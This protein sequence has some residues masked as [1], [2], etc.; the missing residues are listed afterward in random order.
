MT[1]AGAVLGVV[2]FGRIGQKA[3][4][5]G[6]ALGMEVLAYDPVSEPPAEVRCTDLRDL[7]TRSDVITLH[8]PLLET[9]Q[10][11]VDAELLRHVKPGAVLV[12]CGRG[13]LVDMDAVHAA[14]LDGRLGGV[15]LDVFDPEP[16]QHHP[17]FDHP[18]VVLTPHLMGLSRQATSATFLDAARGV[19]AVLE[20]P[21]SGGRGQPRLGAGRVH[22]HHDGGPDMKDLLTGKVLLVSGGTQGLGAGIARAAVREGAAV[23]VSGRNVRHGEQVAAELR[24]TGAEASFVRT[25]ISDVAQ[26]RAAVAATVDRHGRIDAL[27]NAAGLTTR[28][29]MLDTTPELFD[30]H[31]AVNL[32]GPF[33]LMQAAIADMARRGQPGTIVNVLSIDSHGGQAI[34]AP[35]VAAKAGPGGCDQERRPRPPLGPDPDQRP[36]HGLVRHRRRERHPAADPRC[37]RRLAG[38]GRGEPPD[39][40]ARPGRRDRRLRGLPALRPQWR[41]HRVAHRLGPERHRWPRMT[42]PPD[43]PS[44]TAPH[45]R[46]T[47]CAWA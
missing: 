23:V 33:F 4:T 15:G 6:A 47:P 22:D 35:Y 34:L 28:G 5:L 2:G 9:T 7:V 46:S 43:R 18:D 29:T 37:R 39:G 41:G 38:A 19:V 20:R 24:A 16:P 30:Q 8:L 44:V 42:L 10:H 36:E 40:Q 11:L 17:L 25:D 13:A 26:A 45:L 3:A 21:S 1:S 12:N 31:V 14:L 27:V 32:R